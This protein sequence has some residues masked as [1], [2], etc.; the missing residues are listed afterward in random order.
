MGLKFVSD[1]VGN[2]QDNIERSGEMASKDPGAFLQDW[3]QTNLPDAVV[4]LAIK[5]GGREDGSGF[6]AQQALDLGQDKNL[7]GGILKQ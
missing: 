1:L 4:D 6:L 7:L 3:I 2:V 5:V